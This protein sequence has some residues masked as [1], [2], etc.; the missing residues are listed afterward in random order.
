MDF[1]LD[2]TQLA[3]IEVADQI[4]AGT[5]APERLRQI[6]DDDWFHAALWAELAKADLLGLCL[7]EADG[8]G[9]FG[10]LEACLLLERVGRHV[11]PCRRSTA[12]WRRWPSAAGGHPSCAPAGSVPSPP[13]TRC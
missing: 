9:G 1:G 3:A 11:P 2:D 8:E 6:E 12:W 10:F 13:A 4:L 7:P 5:C